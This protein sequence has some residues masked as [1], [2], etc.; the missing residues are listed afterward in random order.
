MPQYFTH[1]DFQST[2]VS[3][4]E[5]RVRIIDFQSARYGPAEYDLASLVY[6]P[7]V[8][9]TDSQVADVIENYL[10]EFAN[11]NVTIVPSNFSVTIRYVAI[12][13]LMQALGAFC[14][15]SS[16]KGKNGF[17]RY[18]PVAESRLKSLLEVS[19][20]SLSNSLLKII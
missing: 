5:N 1:R 18:I 3:I 11:Q 14:F 4:V 19:D 6:D 16:V 7:Y 12:S 9:L 15:L 20:I 13:R 8:K 2:N 17:R 10:K